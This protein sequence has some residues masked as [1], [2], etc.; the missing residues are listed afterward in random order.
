MRQY[1]FK[2]IR[3]TAPKTTD[4]SMF[5]VCLYVLSLH[6]K[7]KM[8]L[9][10]YTIFTVCVQAGN[11]AFYTGCRTLELWKPHPY[12]QDVLSKNTAKKHNMWVS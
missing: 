4:T 12:H 9:R 2:H 10:N 1:R 8:Y 6:A 3:G 11:A 5:A 7:Q